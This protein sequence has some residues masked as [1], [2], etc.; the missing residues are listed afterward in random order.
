MKFIILRNNL[1]RFLKEKSYVIISFL[2][3]F[4][5]IAATSFV[6]T[7]ESQKVKIGVTKSA[8]ELLEMNNNNISVKEVE[9]DEDYYVNLILGKYDAYVN[10]EDGKYKVTTVR[11]ST[12]GK[13]LS[14]YL[15]KGKSLT[16]S[17]SSGSNHYKII[18]TV[19]AMSSMVLSLILYRFYFDDRNGLDKR[20]YL[21]GVSN[22]SYVL[23]QVVFNFLILFITNLLSGLILLPLFDLDITW[24]LVLY[25]LLIELF[26]ANFGMVLSTLTKKNQ[27]ALLIGTM[28]SV[29]TMLLSG[30]LFSVKKGSIQDK[31]HYIFPQYYISNLG[32]NIDSNSTNL[33]YSITVIVGYTLLFFL[34]AN[35]LQNRKVGE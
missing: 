33:T 21:S 8:I 7:M 35:Y 26:S 19:M 16:T 23:Q 6:V 17:T 32:K 25:I 2:L 1:Q 3:V 14:Q 15:N 28:V 4:V 18:I 11:N 27:G 9:R 20:I 5:T 13:K 31:I 10:K 12:L 30:A 24:K 34:I 29:L 22:F